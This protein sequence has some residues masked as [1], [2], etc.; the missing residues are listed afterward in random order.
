MKLDSMVFA[1]KVLKPKLTASTEVL[2]RFEAEASTLSRLPASK[3]QRAIDVGTL[4]DGRPYLVM[5]L[6]RGR[7]LDTVIEL[8]GPLPERIVARLSLQLLDILSSCHRLGI[9][10]RDVKPGNVHICIPEGTEE[11]QAYLLD[12]G[13][14]T[15]PRTPRASQ[16]ALDYCTP[17]YSAPEVG[18]GISSAALDVYSTGVLMTEMLSAELPDELKE[19]TTR[20]FHLPDWGD[21]ELTLPESARKSL[22]FPLI[23]RAVSPDPGERFA[24]AVE[25]KEALQGTMKKFPGHLLDAATIGDQEGLSPNTCAFE[26]RLADFVKRTPAPTARD[27]SAS[28]LATQQATTAKIDFRRR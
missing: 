5:Q 3:V 14:A 25:M 16:I 9:V 27:S 10:H 7:Q 15:N 6:A 28:P 19:R 20:Q 11:T 12:F 1:I 4:N 8:L 26:R 13:I 24:S 21:E 22:L 23:A 17:Q 2:K 18:D